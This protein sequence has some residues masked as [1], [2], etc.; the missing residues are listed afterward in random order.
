M[1]IGYSESYSASERSDY[2]DAKGRCFRKEDIGKYVVVQ[3]SRRNKKVMPKMFLADRR[4][5][6]RFWWT[7]DSSYAMVF[8]KKSAAEFQA[9]RYKYNNVR[10]QQITKDMADVEWFNISYMY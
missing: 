1:K 10:V 4:M 9:S 5:T 6:S 7:P 8:E 3:N 2:V